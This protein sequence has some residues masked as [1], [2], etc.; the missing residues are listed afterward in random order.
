MMNDIQSKPL[1]NN[2]FYKGCDLNHSTWLI[3]TDVLLPNNKICIIQH[4]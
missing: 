4:G 1:R 3:K 2:G